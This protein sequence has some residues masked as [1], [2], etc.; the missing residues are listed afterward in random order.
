M[1]TSSSNDN[2]LGPWLHLPRLITFFLAREELDL[3]IVRA[4]FVVCRFEFLMTILFDYGYTFQD[5]ALLVYEPPVLGAP[6]WCIGLLVHW[7]IGSS[8][9]TKRRRRQND[10]KTTTK[11]RQRDYFE[12]APS[13]RLLRRDY[14]THRLRDE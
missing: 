9:T 10:A 6:Y 8:E 1:G 13:K 5:S 4:K 3:D 12:R 7:F 14:E 11:R 2:S